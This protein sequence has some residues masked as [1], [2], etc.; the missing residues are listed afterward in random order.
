MKSAG[1]VM[2]ILEAYDLTRCAHSAAQLAGCDDKTVARYVAIRDGGGD[3]AGRARR[4][5]VI[6]AY[7]PKVEEW[8]EASQAKIRADVVHERLTAMGFSGTDRITRRAV[9]EAKTAYRDGHRGKYRPWI[10]EPGMWLQVD[11]GEGWDPAEVVRALLQEEVV[12]RDAATRR[13]RRKS[14]NF[15]TS[16][17]FS[18]WRPEESSIPVATQNALMTLEWVHRHETWRFL[19]RRAP[20]RATSS[21]RWRTRR[22]RP[23]CGC[24]GSP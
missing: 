5:R 16:K 6:D 20:G 4:E 15:P 8:V 18:S 3:P 22:S 13:M 1:D 24:R 11:W 17:T 7:L 14:A 21:R 2:Q 10:P 19:E 23:T 12:G 9:A